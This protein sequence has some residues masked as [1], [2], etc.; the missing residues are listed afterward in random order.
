[1]NVSF[2]FATFCDVSAY[3]EFAKIF[4][5]VYL[6]DYKPV[7]WGTCTKVINDVP[8]KLIM[9]N[10]SIRSSK[11]E[12]TFMLDHDAL[13]CMYP[14]LSNKDLLLIEQESHS[15]V[16]ISPKQLVYSSFKNA[17]YDTAN[18]ASLLIK[19]HTHSR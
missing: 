5:S 8:I 11:F 1:M 3:L 12:I 4:K 18:K 2:K 16:S 10:E 9:F 13:K 17:M 19:N 15:T 14:Q 6:D 7:G